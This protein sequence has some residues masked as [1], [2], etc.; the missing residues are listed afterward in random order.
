MGDWKADK[1]VNVNDN[2]DAAGLRQHLRGS[3]CRVFMSDMKVRVNDAFYYPDLVVV[4]KEGYISRTDAC[5]LGRRAGSTGFVEPG[6]NIGEMYRHISVEQSGSH[7]A[8]GMLIVHGPATSGPAEV[9][10]YCPLDE[11]GKALIKAAMRQLGMSARAYHRILKI[12][13]TIADLA[14]SERIETAHLAEALQYRPRR[15]M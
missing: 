7:R 10:E 9:R 8:D 12:S 5:E 15:Q 13:R 2:G 1:E 4:W 3:P 6:L 11:A 14:A